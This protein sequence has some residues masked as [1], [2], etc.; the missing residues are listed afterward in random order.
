M[1]CASVAVLLSSCGPPSTQFSILPT[2]QGVYMGSTANNKVDILWVIKNSG[3]MYTKQQLL[4]SGFSSFISNFTQGNFDYQMGVITG[5]LT[6]SGQGGIL[7]GA[8]SILIPTT[9]SL[10]SV[11]ATNVEVGDTGSF[12]QTPFDA[13]ELGLGTALLSGANSGFIRS[14]AQLAV[15]FVSDSDMDYSTATPSTTAANLYTFLNTLKP[16]VYNLTTEK[17]TPAFTVSAVIADDTRS[18]FVLNDCKFMGAPIY[19]NGLAFESLVGM[20]AGSVAQICS[21]DFSSGLTT[22]SNSIVQAITEIKLGRVPDTSTI[23]VT[24]N[25]VVVPQSSSNG[26]TYDSVNNQILFSGTGIPQTDT[27]I[28]ID[29]TP[30]TIIL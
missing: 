10:S 2:S 16:P 13:T 18:D 21:S 14:G 15:I 26:W 29:Y 27:Q 5:D 9:P 28:N 3:T 8:P 22:I 4:A 11:F 7:Q 25:G 6:A 12:N 30:S 1:A 17:Y 19:E 23:V 24:F 20:T